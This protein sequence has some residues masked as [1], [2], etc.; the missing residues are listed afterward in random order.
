MPVLDEL[1]A[2]TVGVRQPV[3]EA[4]HRHGG[5]D[6][7]LFGRHVLFAGTIQALGKHR[8]RRT[9]GHLA[10]VTAPGGS[11]SNPAQL[12]TLRRL[13][14]SPV[15]PAGQLVGEL[16]TVGG[17][18]LHQLCGQLAWGV[19]SKAALLHADDGQLLV[20]S[21]PAAQ[22]LLPAV[23]D[24]LQ[25][26]PGEVRAGTSD[27]A[28]ADRGRPGLSPSCSV[29]VLGDPGQGVRVRSSLGQKA[30]EVVGQGDVLFAHQGAFC[31]ASGRRAA[32]GRRLAAACPRGTGQA[33]DRLG[34]ARQ[35]GTAK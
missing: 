9:V 35:A 25:H 27:T 21:K 1:G 15:Q 32:R 26:H 2:G 19:L 29:T 7:Q 24:F 6:N 28:L 12:E 34:Q 3:E 22:R 16:D 13:G 33:A 31:S 20:Q 8:G 10:H 11:R 23:G 5:A 17:R 4:G 14:V 18:V 30:A